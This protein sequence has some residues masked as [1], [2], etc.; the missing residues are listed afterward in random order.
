MVPHIQVQCSIAL[1]H[2][3]R[4]SPLQVFRCSRLRAFSCGARG[5]RGREGR[6]TSNWGARRCIGRGVLSIRDPLR[7]LS[8][9]NC[10]RKKSRLSNLLYIAERLL[11]T[12]PRVKC[13]PSTGSFTLRIRSLGLVHYLITYCSLSHSRQQ[14]E[15]EGSH[16]LWCRQ[17]R[18]KVWGQ[19]GEGEGSR[20]Q[21]ASQYLQL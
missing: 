8:T 11:L 12:P 3:T 10:R 2:R 19:Q 14:G 18:S 16:S 9:Y 4:T 1:R 15:G 5:E 17:L 21:A 20:R 7:S 13:N 6:G